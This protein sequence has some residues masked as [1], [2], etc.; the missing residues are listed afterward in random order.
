MQPTRPLTRARAML[1]ELPASNTMN[2]NKPFLSSSL[3]QVFQYS[4]TKLANALPNACVWFKKEQK[5]DNHSMCS[6]FL[7]SY[8]PPYPS[9]TLRISQEQLTV[10]PVVQWG[11]HPTQTVLS[12]DCGDPPIANP[13]CAPQSLSYQLSQGHCAP[14]VSPFF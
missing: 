6:A 7:P 10:G 3:P 5:Q 11:H 14:R 1:L 12:E 4:N 13:D 8:C 2:Q 9:L